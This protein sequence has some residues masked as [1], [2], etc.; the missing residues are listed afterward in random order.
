MK[1]RYVF[2]LL[3]IMVTVGVVS[4]TPAMGFEDDVE[5]YDTGIED[6]WS[7]GDGTTV[8]LSTW[9]TPTN[10]YIKLYEYKPPG[11]G[12]EYESFSLNE[13]IPISYFAFTLD[14]NYVLNPVVS[15]QENNAEGELRFYNPSGSYIGT[16]GDMFTKLEDNGHTRNEQI[17]I[18]FVKTGTATM[19]MYADG[20]LMKIFTLTE[21]VEYFTPEL[22]VKAYTPSGS[23]GITSEMCIDDITTGSI[24]GLGEEW[25]PAQS[26]I[27]TT[28]GIQFHDSYPESTFSIDLIRV[29]DTYTLNT[30]TIIGYDGVVSW[31]RVSVFEEN[32]GLYK[33]NLKRDD[34][35]IDTTY[36]T[37][38][39]ADTIGSIAFDQYAYVSDETAT[40]T[41]SLS[42]PDF[43]T[44]TYQADITDLTGATLATETITSLSGSYDYAFTDYDTGSYYVLFNRITKATGTE[45]LFAY[46]YCDINEALKIEGNTYLFN[47]T[48]ADNATIRMLQGSTYYNTTSNTTGVYSQS[49]LSI[50]VATTFNANTTSANLTEFTF[51]PESAGVIDVD[52]ILFPNMTDYWGAGNTTAYGLIYGT[53]HQPIEGATVTIFNGTWS[54]TT[55]ASSTGFYMFNDLVNASNYFIN[56][57]ASGYDTS[58]DYNVSMVNNTRQDIELTARYT[59]TIQARDTTT[60]SYI[61]E[62]DAYIDGAV[63]STTNGTIIFTDV[64]YGAYSFSVSADDYYPSSKSYV[65]DED[66][67]IT[68]DLTRLESQYYNPHYVK[69]IVKDIWRTTYSGVSVNVY[70]GGS[71]SGDTYATGETGADGSITFQMYENQEYTLT[72]VDSINEIDETLTL[73]PQD[74]HYNVYVITKTIIPDDQ[75]SSE[76][77][78]I[79]VSKELINNTHAYINVTYVDNLAET[80]GL[81]VY[82]NQSI[83]NDPANQTVIDSYSG[84]NNSTVISFIVDDYAGQTYFVNI[85][86]DHV[87]FGDVERTYAVT[88]DGMENAHGFS[89]V[90]TWLAIGGIMF[91][92]MVFKATNARQGAFVVCIVAWVFI[93]LGWFD[94]L[95]DKGVLAITA[96]VTLA[97]IL[98][99]A[100]IMA[101]GE[102]EG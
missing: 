32:Y 95:G 55:N 53:Y 29:S 12:T 91:S 36:F 58:E 1:S 6:V 3:L 14:Y 82:L 22:R 2:L 76:E 78:D 67:E 62:F 33:L 88:F 48:I 71:A 87:T 7:I 5:R 25:S 15:T 28:Y 47:G 43:V 64:T 24:V 10:H 17:R 70:Q 20:E 34:T 66:R 44:Y 102:K 40:I 26:D 27:I 74:D 49:D 56:A 89:Q 30:T 93:I 72:F 45:V 75:Y 57:S 73:Y 42:S 8:Q 65:I 61:S 4:V 37:Y 60:G 39:T 77:L 18:E 92:G 59:V 50:D 69:F 31:D 9:G 80:T 54:N 90:Y 52:L 21:N 63:S 51:T 84:A 68:F 46:D 23:Y 94:N 100:A 86:I 35:S 101:K 81:D 19:S 11:V 85:D 83:T 98:S 16:S 13:V 41:Y 96:G 79:S 97:T 99:I 38:I